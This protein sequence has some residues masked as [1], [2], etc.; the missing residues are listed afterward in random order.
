MLIFTGDAILCERMKIKI[1]RYVY[2]MLP[3]FKPNVTLLKVKRYVKVI[4]AIH[5]IFGRLRTT[6]SRVYSSVSTIYAFIY[7][8]VGLDSSAGIAT[9]Y[10]LDG[11]G[12]ESRWDEIFRTRP[13]RP[14]DPPSL[15]H[16]G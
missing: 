16:N 2:F 6:W 9:R 8:S 5:N 12:I 15:L 14:W 3:Y 10:G 11:P 4:I 7:A 13:D 1:N